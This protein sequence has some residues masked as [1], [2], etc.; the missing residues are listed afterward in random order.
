[1][2]VDAISEDLWRRVNRPHK[3]LKLNMVLE[4]ITE[5]AKEFKGTIV[6]ETMLVNCIDYRGEF[7]KIAGFLRRL[8]KLDKAY[9]AIPTRPP[10]ERWVKPAA[11]KVINAAFQTFSK[12]LGA[13]RVEYLIGYEGDAFVFTEN[14]EDLLGIT[15]V[16]PMRKE[17]VEEFLRKAKVNQQTIEKLLRENKIIELEYEGNTYYMRKLLSK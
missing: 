10:A 17:A 15:A 12:N 11:E 16:H 6:S 3:D 8:K 1:L 2:K 5:F 4:G 7:E 14:V 9:V 13:D